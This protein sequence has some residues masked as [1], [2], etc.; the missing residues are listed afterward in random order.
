ML[1]NAEIQ[2]AFVFQTKTFSKTD[3]GMNK[4]YNVCNCIF[5]FLRL[6][7]TPGLLTSHHVVLVTVKDILHVNHNVR[8]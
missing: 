4:M 2:S 1:Y 8:K 3:F 5:F 7:I 6:I